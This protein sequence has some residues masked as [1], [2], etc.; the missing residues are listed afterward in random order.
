[1]SMTGNYDAKTRALSGVIT[2]NT[3]KL[4]FSCVRHDNFSFAIPS[5]SNDTGY[6]NVFEQGSTGCGTE[7]GCVMQIR[8]IRK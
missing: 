5:G 7:S 4:A 6:Q 8:F 2:T 3:S 1:M